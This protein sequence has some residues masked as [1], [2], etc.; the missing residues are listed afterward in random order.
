MQR[1]IPLWLSS[2]IVELYT[3]QGHVAGA[4]IAREDGR[5]LVHARR[6]VVLACGGFPGNDSLKQRVYGHVSAGKSH[7]SL[8]PPGNTGDGLRLAQS[9]GGRFLEEVHQPAAWTPVS[10]VPQPDGSTIPFPHFFDRGKPG[11]ISVDRRGRRFVNEARSY[12]VYVPAMLEACRDDAEAEAWIVCDHAAIRRFGLGALGPAPM[13]I[14]PF[15]QSGYIKRSDS[16][17]GLA[18]ACGIDA[19]GLERTLL[20]FN[21]PAQRGEDPEFDRGSDAY[22]RF[23]GA[24]GH[25]PNP[26]VAPLALPP[27]YAVRVVAERARHVRRHRHQCGRAGRRPGGQARPRPLCGRQRR[28]QRDGRHL[29]RRRHHH[30][31]GHDVRLYRRAPHGRDGKTENLCLRVSGSSVD[32]R[33]RAFRCRVHPRLA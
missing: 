2:P 14:G 16:V 21:G 15:L 1:D 27:F 4:F 25:E 31:P 19:D 5:V 32:L 23:N 12:H 17:R 3:E 13:R 20:E 29:S 26:C 18:Q 22:Q 28:R 24:P 8:P 10:L 30:R 9:V 11:Y 6:G 33:Q 7:A